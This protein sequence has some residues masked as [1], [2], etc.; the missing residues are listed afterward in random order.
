MI[1]ERNILGVK[2]LFIPAE[3]EGL[4]IMRA[5]PK[6]KIK[7]KRVG[8]ISAIQFLK[9]LDTVRDYL[10]K[11]GKEVHVAGQMVGCNAAKAIKIKKDVDAFLFV[12]S[13]EFHPLELIDSTKIKDIYFF[14]PVSEKF[15]K[16]KKEE[17]E[18]IEKRR[19]AKFAKYMM[20]KKVG[21]IVSLKPGQQ[22][23]KAALRFKE[24]LDKES[25]VFIGDEIDINR[26]EDFNDIEMWV[27][28]CCPRLEGN[29]IISLKDIRK[30]E[31]VDYHTY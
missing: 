13:G 19:N 2:T 31:L 23:L 1:E 28:T 26:L 15:S 12:G 8:L 22:A 6:I 16:F 25:F 11:G 17:L 9:Y 21:I 20:S 4:N 27:N 10:E 14:N 18:R 30:S 7:E 29:K 3:V 24:D 5:L